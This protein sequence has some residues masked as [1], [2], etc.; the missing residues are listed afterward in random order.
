MKAYT[1]RSET[2][3]SDGTCFYV[4][5]NSEEYPFDTLAEAHAFIDNVRLEHTLNMTA[6]NWYR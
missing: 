5:V 3:T 2:I 4:T 1:Y 6:K